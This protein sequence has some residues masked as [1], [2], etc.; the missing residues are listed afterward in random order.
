MINKKYSGEIKQ[1]QQF[2]KI[3]GVSRVFM[4]SM[5]KMNVLAGQLY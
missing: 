4:L 2:T 3:L 1:T 5:N